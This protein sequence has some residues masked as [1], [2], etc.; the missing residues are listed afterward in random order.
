MKHGKDSLSIWSMLCLMLLVLGM[1][2]WTEYKNGFV[3]NMLAPLTGYAQAQLD[4]AGTGT[5]QD[6]SCIVGDYRLSAEEIRGDGYILTIVYALTRQDG[7]TL[8]ENLRFGDYSNSAV[9]SAG[10]GFS[11]YNLSSDGKTLWFTTEWISNENLALR[12]RATVTFTDL[13]LEEADGESITLME[14]SWD[15]NL[16]LRYRNAAR[17]VQTENLTITGSGSGMYEIA[18]VRVS[19]LGI[20]IDMQVTDSAAEDSLMKD[21]SVSLLLQNGA[22][23]NVEHINYGCHGREGQNTFTVEWGAQFDQ[24]IDLGDIQDLVIC[25]QSVP[26]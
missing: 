24:S 6:V 17:T 12:R 9:A 14:G 7:G 2:L 25:G 1:L 16:I 4:S 13:M 10:G 21:F 26:M 11:N 19:S 8:S 3:S 15:L 23:V 22:A 18:K 5:F 20:H